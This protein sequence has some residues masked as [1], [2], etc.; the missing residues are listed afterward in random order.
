MNQSAFNS[1]YPESFIHQV[2]RLGMLLRHGNTAAHEQH[3]GPGPRQHRHGGPHAFHGQ[4]RVLALLKLNSPISQ[5]ELA[6]LLGIRPQSLGEVLTKLETAGFIN[7]E[8]D[9]H[10][11]RAR[12][13]HLTEL[14]EQEATKLSERPSFDPLEVLT[15]E[16]K[17]TFIANLDR[18]VSS[19]AE[20]FDA[21]RYDVPQHPHGPNCH[22]ESEGC[23]EHNGDFP[24]HR[25]NRKPRRP[26]H[27]R[28]PHPHQRRSPYQ[29]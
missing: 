18:I 5:R 21:E 23:H 14:G 29:R 13:V 22:H 27:G 16:E 17:A 26:E 12:L 1:E 24:P 9:P 25:R 10:D 15:E 4:G 19:L 6:Y 7:R 8:V 2:F 3:H 11:A 28:N 20:K